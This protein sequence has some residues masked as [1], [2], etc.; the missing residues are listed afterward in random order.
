MSSKDE[1]FK[2]SCV[3]KSKSTTM[4]DEGMTMVSLRQGGSRM[5][6]FLTQEELTMCGKVRSENPEKWKDKEM[7]LLDEALERLKDKREDK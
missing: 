4:N 7:D 3:V 2:D 1:V 5:D 6:V